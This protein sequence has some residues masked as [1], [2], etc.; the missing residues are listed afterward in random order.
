MKIAV[1]TTCSDGYVIFL[2]HFIK[3]ILKHNPGFD[4]DFLIYC[5]A[6]LKQSNRNLLS[7]LYSG[8]K[9]VD[10]DYTLYQNN[11]KSD[12]KFYSIECF[13]QTYDRIIY[14]GSDMLCLKPLDELFKIAEDIEGIAMPKE[15]RRGGTLPY[16][17]GSMIIGK[18]CL[19]KKTYAGLLG[20]NTDTHRSHLKDQKLYNLFFKDKIKEIHQKYNVLVSELDFIEWDEILL[21]H[22]IYK[23]VQKIETD[24][25]KN[26]G[27]NLL[28]LWRAYD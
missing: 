14:W 26:C 18:E 25:L 15:R 7:E 20:F 12:M 2:D 22:Y 11:N 3:S 23:P 24:Q 17:N 9:F 10:V 6:R 5:D 13:Q 8:F 16:N 19:N 28:K 1:S 27:H 4:K 21:L